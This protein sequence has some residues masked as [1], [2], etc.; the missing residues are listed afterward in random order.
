MQMHTR[1]R[2]NIKHT[3]AILEVCE[4][5]QTVERGGESQDQQNAERAKRLSHATLFVI[6]LGRGIISSWAN[7]GSKSKT[8]QGKVRR[9]AI[10]GRQGTTLLWEGNERARET[11][12]VASG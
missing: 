10:K 7:K 1:N 5:S 11:W 4:H 9:N 6:P 2:Q 12:L 8:M 3:H